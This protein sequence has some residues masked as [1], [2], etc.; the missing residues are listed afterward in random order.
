MNNKQF[1]SCLEITHK[2]LNKDFYKEEYRKEIKTGIQDIILISLIGYILY[3]F[4]L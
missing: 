1:K 4:F 3:Y 2:N